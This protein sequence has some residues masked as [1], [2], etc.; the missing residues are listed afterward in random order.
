MAAAPLIGISLIS[1]TRSGV[2]GKIWA[3]RRRTY[4]QNYLFLMVTIAKC[5]ICV[6]II[7]DKHE[8][9]VVECYYVPVVEGEHHHHRYPEGE[10]GG[11]DGVGLVH[12]QPAYVQH[13]FK[14][15]VSRD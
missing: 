6:Y 5:T 12:N 7:Y 8:V 1:Y 4:Y 15:I 11:D 3:V 10:R 9:Y 2:I 14:G 13:R